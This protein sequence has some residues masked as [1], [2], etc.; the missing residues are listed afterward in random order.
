MSIK[1]VSFY[2]DALPRRVDRQQWRH[3]T[4]AFGATVELY[5]ANG[6]VWND[7]TH[8]P[9]GRPVYLFDE[10]GEIELFD[11]I[12]TFAHPENALYVFGITDMDITK[13]VP[14]GSFN[15][16][17]RIDTPVSKPFWGCQAAAIVLAHKLLEGF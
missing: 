5:E 16:V 4:G 3:V 1:C 12:I 10:T 11:P 17:V 9:K 8:N 7:E 14:P 2:E 13:V 6:F 15:D